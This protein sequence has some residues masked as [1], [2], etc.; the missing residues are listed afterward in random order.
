MVVAN[1]RIHSIDIH[2]GLS[3]I[4]MLIAHVGRYWLQ[5]SSLWLLYAYFLIAN[6]FGTPGFT[7][8]AGLGFGFSWKAAELK[9]VPEQKIWLNSFSRTL[10]MFVFAIGYNIFSMFIRGDNWTGLWYWNILFTVAMSRLLGTLTMK[11]SRKIRGAIALAIIG[12]TPLIFNYLEAQSPLSS[13]A[14]VVFYI[15]FNPAYAFSIMFFFP[16]FIIGSLIGEDIKAIEHFQQNSDQSLLLSQNSK[17]L[18]QKW[19]LFGIGLLSLGLVLGYQ[20]STYDFGWFMIKGLNI[21]P[22][23]DIQTIPFFLVANSYANCFFCAG[24]NIVL[25]LS[26]F[27]L[28]DIAKKT[29]KNWKLAYFG[30]YSLTIYFFHYLLLIIPYFTAALDHKTVWLPL[31]GFLLILWLFVYILDKKW[32]GKVSV[33]RAVI[34]L[35]DKLFEFFMK[36]KNQE[37]S[38]ENTSDEKI[39]F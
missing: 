14:S 37:I 12:L 3:I 39:A 28:V 8:V 31:I 18:V 15:L 5:S 29:K 17:K 27:Y 34:Y 35:A 10:S 7:F 1:S 20:G 30:R 6:I 2:R 21:N 11:F 24:C 32:K 13:T 19:I 22:N 25:I 36:R 38:I 9:K 16:F 4:L 23:W 33:E 26:L